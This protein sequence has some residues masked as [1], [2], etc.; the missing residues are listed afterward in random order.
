MLQYNSQQHFHNIVKHGM[1]TYLVNQLISYII[2]CRKKNHLSLVLYTGTEMRYSS[3]IYISSLLSK[4]KLKCF[5]T[6]RESADH[7]NSSCHKRSAKIHSVNAWIFNLPSDKFFLLNP[8]DQHSYVQCRL[9]PNCKQV[10]TP[11]TSFCKQLYV[12]LPYALI[13]TLF[14]EVCIFLNLIV[15]KGTGYLIMLTKLITF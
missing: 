11:S 1:F 14:S 15:W 9:L 13:L 5:E 7:Q 8:P 3:T 6:S 4:E 2:I 10:A 12:I